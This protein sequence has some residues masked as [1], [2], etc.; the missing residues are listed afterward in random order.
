LR[1]NSTRWGG[2][3]PRIGG[4]IGQRGKVESPQ[5][6]TKYIAAPGDQLSW[7]N[8]PKKKKKNQR[9][10]NKKRPNRKGGRASKRTGPNRSR[11][12]LVLFPTNNEEEGGFA[13]KKKQTKG[14]VQKRAGKSKVKGCKDPEGRQPS[15]GA[16]CGGRRSTTARKRNWRFPRCGDRKPE[17]PPGKNQQ[18]SL[19]RGGE[20]TAP[21]Q[22]LRGPPMR[23][24]TVGRSPRPQ[25][26]GKRGKG[27][28]EEEPTGSLLWKACW[29][30]GEN[31]FL[32][33]TGK[34]G[35]AEG[36]AET[37]EETAE[38]GEG[39]TCAIRYGSSTKKKF[40]ASALP[41]QKKE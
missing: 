34:K 24:K 22:G 13:K 17:R 21:V 14:G 19:I 29:R 40:K 9:A 8:R 2:V 41:E 30:T 27:K 39:P 37:K 32:L 20:E 5:K 6:T 18:R 38:E 10:G 26:K 31:H 33:G 35:G 36:A 7:G 4:W 23:R 25:T 12:V 28:E 3:K 11:V 16:S 15:K 1:L